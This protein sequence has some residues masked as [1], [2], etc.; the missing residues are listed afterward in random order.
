MC[1]G[2]P[3]QALQGDLNEIPAGNDSVIALAPKY[4]EVVPI[5]TVHP[6]DRQAALDDLARGH[7]AGGGYLKVHAHPQALAAAYARAEPLLRRPGLRC[8]PRSN[9]PPPS[10]S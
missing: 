2:G 6:Y 8:A 4:P 10:H 9:E 5:A 3:H 1:F 7:A